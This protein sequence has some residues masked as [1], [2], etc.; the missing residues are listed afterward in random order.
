MGAGAAIAAGRPRVGRLVGDGGFML[1]PVE[2][3]TARGGR[4]LAGGPAD[5]RRRLR[6]HPQTSR[7][8]I[9]A[10]AT[11]IPTSPIRASPTSPAPSASATRRIAALAEAEPALRRAFA[12][13]R[14]PAGRGRHA[15][16]RRL[17]HPLRRSAG[18][19]CLDGLVG[20]ENGV[21]LVGFGRH[22]PDGRRGVRTGRG[23]SGRLGPVAGAAGAPP[24]TSPRPGWRRSR[25]W[26]T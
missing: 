11:A 3:M 25:R 4:G 10:D 7:T 1:K 6:R 17:R 16:D 26:R 22:C 20:G 2:L 18:E 5:E 9:T 13:R 15:G 24:P 14:R 8:R 12:G 19:G 23:R 21:A